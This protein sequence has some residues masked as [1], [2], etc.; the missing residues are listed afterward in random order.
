L[1][2]YLASVLVCVWSV[3]GSSACNVDEAHVRCGSADDCEIGQECYLGYC[4][5]QESLDAS[6]TSSEAVSKGDAA[7][8]R[9]RGMTSFTGGRA[10]EDASPP[11]AECTMSEDDAGAPEGACCTAAVSCYT[12]AEKTRGVGRCKAGMRACEDGALGAAC[13]GEALPRAEACDNQG[14]DDDCDGKVD[15]VPGL[16]GA[17]MLPASQRA[18][19]AGVYACVAGKKERQCVLDPVPPERCNTRDDDCDGKVDEMFD[20]MKDA[21]NCGA[22][23]TA[24]TAAQ[25]CCGGACVARG[26]GPDGCPECSITQ[27]CTGRT[28]CSGACVDVQNDNANCGTC[29][30]ACGNRQTCCA[31]QCVDTRSDEMNCGACGAV[32]TAGTAP[33]CCGGACTDVSDDRRNCGAC[34]TNCGNV[35]TCELSNGTPTCQGPL[36]FCF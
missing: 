8:R 35:C 25:A 28:C 17:C 13:K 10:D 14:S 32:C 21:M 2:R 36:G 22:C 9:R 29:G 6:G 27:P 31:G 12:G 19:G 30:N 11:P 20:L 33:T 3:L 16:G 7:T 4:V 5:I 18:C 1:K 34:G 15:N 23:G 26:P 24:C